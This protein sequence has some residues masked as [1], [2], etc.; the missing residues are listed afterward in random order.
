MSTD[1]FTFN[2]IKN[3]YTMEFP[4]ASPRL[5]CLHGLFPSLPN[6]PFIYIYIFFK[7]ETILHLAIPS[8][9][10]I[11]S[12]SFNTVTVKHA[13][14][15]VATDAELKLN[16]VM[17]ATR[18]AV[19]GLKVGAGVAETMDVLGKEVCLRRM[20]AVEARMQM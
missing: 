16:Q 10:A 15:G 13:L 18:Y 12:M 20:E 6:P 9:R 19:T 8:L 2:N 5:I 11:P 1:A 14:Q 17:M 7:K 3:Y 4:T